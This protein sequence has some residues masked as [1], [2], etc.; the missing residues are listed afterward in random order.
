VPSGS[1]QRCQA[2]RYLSSVHRITNG[3]IRVGQAIG[4]RKSR[5]RSVQMN[6][7]NDESSKN[8]NADDE[9]GGVPSANRMSKD[10]GALGDDVPVEELFDS[11]QLATLRERMENVQQSDFAEVQN[12]PSASVGELHSGDTSIEAVMET[13]PGFPD[14]VERI[15]AFRFRRT[16][17]IQGTP[18]DYYTMRGLGKTELLLAFERQS[19]ADYFRDLMI[20]GGSETAPRDCDV[21]LIDGNV[22]FEYCEDNGLMLGLIPNGGLD[23]CTSEFSSSD[24]NERSARA[25]EQAKRLER[26]FQQDADSD[27]DSAIPEDEQ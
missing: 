1:T 24:K 19:D 21:V 18:F 16:P 13:V 22:L 7:G 6:R 5:C 25:T 2:R 14:G 15:W 27:Q 12:M 26:L 20:S 4:A 10:G 11:D 23:D 3:A 8:A 17:N 9:N